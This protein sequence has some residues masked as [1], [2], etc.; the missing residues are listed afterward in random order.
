MARKYLYSITG[1]GNCI[2]D[3]PPPLMSLLYHETIG[4]PGG[5]VTSWFFLPD[6]VVEQYRGSWPEVFTIIPEE[7]TDWVA[8]KVDNV[9]DYLLNWMHY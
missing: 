4:G 3:C 7:T 6:E 2:S 1:L 9:D 5:G 8:S